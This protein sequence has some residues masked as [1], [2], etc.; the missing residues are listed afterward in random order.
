[1]WI[2]SLPAMQVFIL[3][4]IFYVI[5]FLLSIFIMWAYIYI[6]KQELFCFFSI[7]IITFIH[8]VWV[9]NWLFF[10]LTKVITEITFLP[11]SHSYLF[12]GYSLY[13]HFNNYINNIKN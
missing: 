2:T 13:F 10:L 7:L 4:F 11:E 1:M 12:V 6:N 5:Y 8:F 9:N 3:F